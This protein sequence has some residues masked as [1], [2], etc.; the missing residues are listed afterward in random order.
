MKKKSSC[1]NCLPLLLRLVLVVVFALP[2]AHSLFLSKAV[3]ASGA[4]KLG[5]VNIVYSIQPLALIG[6]EILG[7]QVRHQ[8]LLPPGTSPHDYALKINDIKTLR[9]ADIIVWMGPAIEPYLE[10]AF[11][12]I[13]TD[14]KKVEIIDIS[15]VLELKNIKPHANVALSSHQ[16][17]LENNNHIEDGFDLHI[18]LSPSHAIAIADILAKNISVVT[19]KQQTYALEALQAF[20]NKITSMSPITKDKSLA[21]ISYQPYVVF[22]DA[23]SYLE[24]YLGIK[25]SG[26]ITD[27]LHNRPGLQ[28]ALGMAKKIKAT[29][30]MCM[31]APLDY[32]EKLTAKLFSATKPDVIR[33][34][35]LAARVPSDMV[36]TDYLRTMI[37]TIKNCINYQVVS[38]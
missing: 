2:L 13:S 23:F 33:L 17:H 6:R 28:H 8:A 22:H 37:E 30:P 20:S 26:A 10:K 12:T 27:N 29:K 4:E 14:Q 9:Q 16:H 35:I 32:D 31:L 36:Y 5:P 19:G 38:D 25:N 21:K 1:I 11:A 34:D 15:N 24:D 7:H 18:W 3:W